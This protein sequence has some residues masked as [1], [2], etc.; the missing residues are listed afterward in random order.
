ML[1]GI[2][3][4]VAI[5]PGFR[6]TH[7]SGLSS[8]LSF[9]GVHCGSTGETTVN[10]GWLNWR[11]AHTL[12]TSCT[13]NDHRNNCGPAITLLTRSLYR[14]SC[15]QEAA[16]V[17]RRSIDSQPQGQSREQP[18]PHS[19]TIDS[20][21]AN[22]PLFRPLKSPVSSPEKST[23]SFARRRKTISHG[24]VQPGRHSDSTGTDHFSLSRP[25]V[26]R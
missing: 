19:T 11:T 4:G 9:I 26:L 2:R 1:F 16:G 14:R 3:L 17:G 6:I 22:A 12:E 8:P 18:H 21:T 10:M 5:D 24:K 23:S 13:S 25:S 20:T 7:H 15:A